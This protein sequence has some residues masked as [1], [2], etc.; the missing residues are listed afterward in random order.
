[1]ANFSSE[2]P[3]DKV[4]F[5]LKRLVDF[6]NENEFDFAIYKAFAEENSKA[7]NRYFDQID[8]E[9]DKGK[10]ITDLKTDFHFT[11]DAIVTD[12]MPTKNSIDSSN[13]GYEN[14]YKQLKE[15]FLNRV[16][17]EVKPK[18]KAVTENLHPTMFINDSFKLFEYIL[19]NHVSQ[20]RGRINDISFYYW[21]MYNDNLII[22]KPF[23][24]QE[25]FSK[26]Y[27]EVIG[28]IQTLK[29]VSNTDRLKHY[30]TSLEWYKTSK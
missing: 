21:K 1:M 19:E 26:N 25:W 14:N 22:Q 7:F 16:E 30:S 9:L 6:S 2:N 5:I 3:I 8:N 18:T 27:S 12:M 29:A 24:F 4:D 23:P 15:L 17:F 28:K 20:N 11:I 10:I 13:R